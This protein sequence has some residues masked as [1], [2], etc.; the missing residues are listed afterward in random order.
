M[1]SELRDAGVS[2]EGFG[3][4]SVSGSRDFDHSRAAHILLRSLP[5]IRDS[6]VRESIAR[7]LTDE[8]GAR[9]QGAGRVLVVEFARSSDNSSTRWAIGNALATLADESV[10][11]DLIL[12]LRDRSFG[13]A[14]E[15]L[16]EA[17]KRTGDAR[18]PAV[19]IEVIDD[20]DVAGHAVS[21]LRSFGPKTALVLL[22][23]AEPKLKA[24][25]ERSTATPFARTQAQKALA[26]V[27]AARG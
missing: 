11:D 20:D 27:A 13:K 4:F 14:R 17:L 6:R 3:S 26:Q 7:S 12:L 8:P 25:S 5:K 16:C 21:V 19:L 10:A 18:A 9:E 22:G 2:T 15:M 23:E 24:L 1:L